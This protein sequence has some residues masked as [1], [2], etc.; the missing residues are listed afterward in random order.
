MTLQSRRGDRGLPIETL[1]GS[2]VPAAGSRLARA[3]GQI[4]RCTQVLLLLVAMG[5]VACLGVFAAH[6]Q[7]R[8]P[9]WLQWLA[10]GGDWVPVVLVSGVIALV[11]IL[12]YQ[13]RRS[14]SSAAV[15]VMIVVGLTATSLYLALSSFWRCTNND[16]PTLISPLLWTASLVKGGIGDVSLDGTGMCPKPTP[17]ALE[18]ARLAIV[19][20]IF[21]SIVGVVAAAFR[22]QS[23]RLRAALA[24]SVTVVVDLDDD[25]ASMIGPIAR[26]LHPRGALVLVADDP[27]KACV[28]ESRRL[29]ARVVQVSF[30]RPEMLASHRFWRRLSGLYLLSADASTNLLRLSVV[31][32]RLAPVATRRRIPLIVRIDDPWIAEAWRAQQFGHHG[33]GSD[34][35]WAADTV[36]RY[37][38]TARRLVEEILR[39]KA[40]RLIIV[41]GSSQLTLALCAELALR[42]A[43]HRFHAP[44]GEPD[45]PALMLIAADSDE[46]ARDHEARHQRRGFGGGP[47]PVDRVAA[48][49]SLAVVSR[50]VAQTDGEDSNKAVI[51]VDSTAAADSILG[52]RLAA[53]HPTMP[54]YMYDPAA[55]IDAER[56]PV[57]CELRTYRLGMAL[58]DGHAHD[59]FERAAML[60][61]ERYASSRGDRTTPP[62]L[63]WDRLS[64]FYQGSNRRQLRNALWMVEKIAGHTWNTADGSRD[65]ISPESLSELD[66]VQDGAV[67]TDAA[68]AA[69]E[70]LARLGYSPDASYALAQGDWERWSRYLR[71]RG[72]T[73][74]SRRSF[75]K[76]RHEK[77]VDSWDAVLA[78]P[79]LRGAAL[80]NL[81][82]S[83]A[84]LATLQRLGFDADAAHAMAQAEWED[85]SR[86]LREHGWSRGDTRDDARK[87][88]EKL[89]ADWEAT[90]V[91]PEL[92]AAALK[93]LAGTLIELL[94]LGYRSQP[95]WRTYER[96]GTVTAKRHCRQWS[97]T[98]A[99]GQPLTASAGDWE[100][101]DDGHAWPVRDDIFRASYRRVRRNQWERRGT[102]LARP[103]RPGETVYTLE[104]PVIAADGDVVVQ[105]DRG[106]EW[107]VPADQFSRRYRGPVPVYRGPEFSTAA[108]PES[109]GA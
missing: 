36:S 85:W 101:R 104:G 3:R 58:P 5:L 39:N 74:G 37:E 109:R 56:L 99:S 8:W 26:T 16:H 7:R 55:R 83:E 90:V 102:V 45:L 61:H 88:H 71:E 95:M 14:R 97:C 86:Y 67:V 70:R 9:R 47:L 43:E 107:P 4:L 65:H 50:V 106:E 18:V 53:S 98:T 28:A 77:L 12:T 46:Y 103:A 24:R 42:H 34:H 78:D 69:V 21:I 108:V 41:C 64:G 49:P 19:A 51:V 66:A 38:A 81:A 60:I 31:S 84:A 25:S 68:E 20:A 29:G 13:M 57:A 23:D 22:A 35:L 10:Q 87:R 54:I 59:N 1:W 92:K 82:D 33:G 11:C 75:K 62:A 52:T 91:D 48:K 73:W 32:Q 100:V 27:D 2:G 30:D 79:A 63:P 80:K 94:N 76:K 89:V 44:E 6:W 17:T 15:P 93:S 40:V 105:G 72:W 96:A